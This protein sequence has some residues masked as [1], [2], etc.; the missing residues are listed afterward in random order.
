MA[1]SNHQE[2]EITNVDHMSE[3]HSLE[4]GMTTSFDFFFLQS[5]FILV[6]FPSA[7]TEIAMGTHS[8]STYSIVMILAMNDECKILKPTQWCR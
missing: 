6:F 3:A 4:G 8:T 7:I 5:C 1:I 2:A